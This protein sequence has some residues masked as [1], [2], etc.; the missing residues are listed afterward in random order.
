MGPPLKKLG[1]LFSKF[2]G[3]MSE[4][5]SEPMYT[6]SDG[7]VQQH[8]M[9]QDI[10]Y[11]QM[12]KGKAEA[13]SQSEMNLSEVELGEAQGTAQSN[14]CPLACSSSLHCV[15]SICSS[16]SK[17][18]DS[19]EDVFETWGE[20]CDLLMHKWGDVQEEQVTTRL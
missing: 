11:S 1:L 18:L 5:S 14:E 13:C 15:S 8:C 19:S 17:L 6:I 4:P 20:A 9:W 3:H 2:N 7:I 16:N 10:R 12:E